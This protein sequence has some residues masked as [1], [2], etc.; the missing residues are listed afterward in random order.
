MNTPP[1]SVPPLEIAADIAAAVVG[2]RARKIRKR[3]SPR[4]KA[5]LTKAKRLNPRLTSYPIG[6]EVLPGGTHVVLVSP[7]FVGA[8][9]AGRVI[10][11]TGVWTFVS[12]HKRHA[13]VPSGWRFTVTGDTSRINAGTL[14]GFGYTV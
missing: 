5:E 11:L 12:K 14:R 3:T 8:P 6:V 2:S 4:I 7:H 1:I 10:P 9:A 13:T